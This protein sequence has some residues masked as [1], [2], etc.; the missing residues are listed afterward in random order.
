MSGT[1]IV[2]GT[3]DLSSLLAPPP[4]AT[5]DQPFNMALNIPQGAT[6]I[7]N[8]GLVMNPDGSMGT[9]G[10]GFGGPAP[11]SVVPPGAPQIPSQA[12]GPLSGMA[13][14]PSPG[15]PPVAGAASGVQV[16]SQVPG[17]LSG[18]VAPQSPGAT[19]APPAPGTTTASLTPTTAPSAAPASSQPQ[20][21]Y[22]RAAIELMINHAAKQYNLNPTIFRNMLITESNLDPNAV[23]PGGEAGIGQFMPATAKA[24]GIDPMNP[25]QA[26]PAAALFLRNNLNKFGGNYQ[27]AVAAYNWGPHNVAQYGVDNAPASTKSYVQKITGQA[28]QPH[29]GTGGPPRPLSAGPPAPAPAPASP[30]A[31]APVQGVPP[32]PNTALARPP[33]GG[34]LPGV[35]GG[36]MSLADAFS[37]AAQR[38]A[39]KHLDECP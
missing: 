10:G 26:I 12:P 7:G 25:E 19:N 27:A 2:P 8:A 20:H 24:M 29:A 16:P 21:N 35:L 31:P 11:A 23:G 15:M 22:S 30:P 5:A 18:M 14:P 17:P 36:P 4:G 34:G 39:G 38:R 32:P 37:R 28:L 9:P 13:A 33:G 1:A 3:Q 6:P